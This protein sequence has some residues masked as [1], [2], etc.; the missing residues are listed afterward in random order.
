MEKDLNGGH[1]STFLKYFALGHLATSLLLLVLG[2][3]SIVPKVWAKWVFVYGLLLVMLLGF[4]NIFLLITDKKSA[5][6]GEPIPNDDMS[7]DEDYEVS[8]EEMVGGVPDEENS[9]EDNTDEDNTEEDDTESS[10]KQ[11]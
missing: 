6:M 1:F 3:A 11:E 7:D 9:D 10:N 4:I 8:S 5:D 2:Y